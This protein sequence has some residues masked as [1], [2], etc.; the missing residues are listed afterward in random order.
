MLA[1]THQFLTQKIA[2]IIR[3]RR[4]EMVEQPP[5]SE[6]YFCPM[7]QRARVSKDGNDH[8]VGSKGAPANRCSSRF[9]QRHAN[10][11]TGGFFEAE[12]GA[13]F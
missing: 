10:L 7:M 3:A 1:A 13:L 4:Q 6:F 12:A 9:L 11:S 5:V 2:E 8:S